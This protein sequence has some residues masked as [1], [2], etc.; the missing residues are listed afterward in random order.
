MVQHSASPAN[1]SL[2]IPLL[3]CPTLQITSHDS[4]LAIGEEQMQY[5]RGT[6]EVLSSVL[7][8]YFCGTERY[9]E[10][11]PSNGRGTFHSK[12]RAL[13]TTIPCSQV[14]ADAV[15]AAAG[16]RS[17]PHRGIGAISGAPS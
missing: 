10:G 4:E 12:A 13:R 6:R 7:Y 2:T 8:R 11:Y 5:T 9:G 14:A 17:P 16:T 15:N 1:F 3:R